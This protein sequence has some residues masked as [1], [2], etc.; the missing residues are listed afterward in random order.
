[1]QH[2]VCMVANIKLHYL[3]HGLYMIHNLLFSVEFKVLHKS[4]VYNE[5]SVI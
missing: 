4:H 3:S 5:K 2:S 1:M